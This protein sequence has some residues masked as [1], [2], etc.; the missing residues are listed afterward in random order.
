MSPRDVFGAMLRFYRTRAGLSQ[1]QFGARI[2]YSGDQVGK[3]E[4]GQRRP[5][6][7]LHRRVCCGPEK[8]T[9]GKRLAT[10]GSG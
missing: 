6:E 4:N 10:S 9:D 3:V 2:C 8:G 7:E 1:D 5:T